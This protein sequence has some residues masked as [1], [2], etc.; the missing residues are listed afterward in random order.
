MKQK[1]IAAGLVAGVLLLAATDAGACGATLFGTGQGSRFQAYRA[2]IPANVLIYATP[3]LADTSAA[4][5]PAIQDGLRKAGHQVTVVSDADSLSAALAERRYDV[6]IADA[7]D[8]QAVADQLDGS[9]ARTGVV[10]VVAKGA[11]PAGFAPDRFAQ[12]LR[13]SA[14]IGQFLK[15]INDAMSAR[16]K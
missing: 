10:P 2:R 3:Q 1:P 9:V 11:A 7:G 4:A 14:G 6:V 13:A 12:S 5:E 8:A 15:A 16:I